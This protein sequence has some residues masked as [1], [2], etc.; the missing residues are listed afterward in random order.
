[1]TIHPYQYNHD[2]G[3]LYGAIKQA[4]V[5]APNV[6]NIIKQFERYRFTRAEST[7]PDGLGLYWQLK[8]RYGSEANVLLLIQNAQLRLATLRYEIRPRNP[9][10]LQV[11]R[12]CMDLHGRMLGYDPIT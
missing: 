8:Q 12:N 7:P 3:H 6:Y 10:Y 4:T 5:H 1:M 2:P 9:K 11:A